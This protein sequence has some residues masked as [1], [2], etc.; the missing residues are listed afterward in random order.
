MKKLVATLVLLSVV[1]S[2]IVLASSLADGFNWPGGFSSTGNAVQQVQPETTSG[3][4]WPEGRSFEADVTS[5]Q[6]ADVAYGLNW[7]EGS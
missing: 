3:F 5:S 1:G 7:P 6:L 2:G 4:N